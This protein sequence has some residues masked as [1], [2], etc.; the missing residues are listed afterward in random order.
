MSLYGLRLPVISAWR[1]AAALAMFS[2]PVAA[3][4]WVDYATVSMSNVTT[5]RLNASRLCYTDGADIAC[6]GAAGL[7]TTS[8]TLSFNNVSVTTNLSAAGAITAPAAAFGNVAVV[9]IS[10]TG[11]SATGNISAAKFIGDGSGLSGISTGAPDKITSGT[12]SVTVNGSSAYVSLTSAGTTWGYLSSGLS[13][14][15]KLS[16]ANVSVTSGIQIGTTSAACAN[17][18]SGT[19]RYNTAAN[20]MEYCN[21]SAWANLGPSATTPVAFMAYKTVNQTVTAGTWTALTWDSEYFDTNN[22]FASNRFTPTVPGYY[23]IRGTAYFQG[24][25]NAPAGVAVAKNGAIYQYNVTPPGTGDW[26]AVVTAIVYMNGSTDYVELWADNYSGTTIYGVGGAAFTSFSGILIGSTG[27]GGGGTTN[28]AGNNTEVQFNSGGLFGSSGNFTW[29]NATST[30]TASNISA[31]SVYASTV[32]LTTGGTTWGYLGSG[33]SYLPNF[34]ASTISSTAGI[35]LGAVSTACGA[36]ISG[37]LRYNTGSNIVDYCNGSAW[38]TFSTAVPADRISTSG[39]A[40][41]ANLAMVMAGNGGTVS[42]TT[43]GTAG[44]AYLDSVGRLVTPGISATTNRTSVTTLYVSRYLGINGSTPNSTYPLDV[45]GSIRTTRGLAIDDYDGNATTRFKL[46]SRSN[47]LFLT[48]NDNSDVWQGTPFEVTSAGDMTLA[49]MVSAKY[50]MAVNGAA[51]E[52]AAA[53]PFISAAV[54]GPGF[55]TSQTVYSFWYQDGTGISNPA[56]G[57][58][59]VMAG[60]GER[61]RVAANGR[62]GIGTVAPGATLDVVGGTQWSSHNYGAA[63]VAYTPGRNTVIGLLDANGQNPWAIA[64]TN[65]TVSGTL[66]FA[67]MPALGDIASAASVAMAITRSGSVGIGKEAPGATLDVSGSFRTN[68]SVVFNGIYGNSSGYYLCNN[69]GNITYGSSC[70]SSDLRLKTDLKPV[71]PSLEKLVK[72]QAYTFYWKDKKARGAERNMGLIAQDVEKYFPEL[73]VN[74][75]DGYKALQYDR[76]AGPIVESIKE[77]KVQNDRQAEALA[78][79]DARIEALTKGLEELRAQVKAL[80]T[81]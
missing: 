59:G 4:T 26:N 17:G 61:V 7:F 36:G 16:S 47:S 71:G 10:A 65:A 79:A 68:S 2:L 40:S 39:V 38:T 80:Q 15:P 28:P 72:L 5:P 69:S 45:S 78:K 74:N 60:G 66:T 50:Y 27:G 67:R 18:I 12:V 20:T 43:G 31:S 13:Y 73:V 33:A 52:A 24:S 56:A 81:K 11:V 63:M 30:L 55:S 42:F 70:T 64:N 35:Q 29:N 21:G 23:L 37:T 54:D 46:F 9:G 48:A 49:S 14:L 53:I 34:R 75:P 76:L 1:L 6:D 19:I 25:S 58:V 77:L 62:V 3:Q 41:G 32:S 8:G 44:T 57:E 22:N 51:P